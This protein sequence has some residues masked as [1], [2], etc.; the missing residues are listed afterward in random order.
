V[1]FAPDRTGVLRMGMDDPGLSLAPS[2]E[3]QRANQNIVALLGNSHSV[4]L[5]KGESTGMGRSN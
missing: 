2:K 1:I 5:R 3:L 4:A